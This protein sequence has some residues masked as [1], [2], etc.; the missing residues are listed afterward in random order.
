[1]TT[2]TTPELVQLIKR[3]GE[4]EQTAS[5][6]LHY[7]VRAGALAVVG[8][9]NPGPGTKRLYPSD[10]ALR[11]A[12]LQAIRNHGI[13]AAAAVSMLRQPKIAKGLNEFFAVGKLIKEPLLVVSEAFNGQEWPDVYWC[14]FQTLADHLAIGDHDNHVVIHVEKLRRH[15]D[16]RAARG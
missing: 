5:D 7:W 6:R 14:S 9:R 12:V 16:A 10:T 8:K 13:P 15:L 2:L 3:P 11:V 1:M 4:D